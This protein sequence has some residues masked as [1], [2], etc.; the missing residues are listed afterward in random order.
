MNKKN[1]TIFYKTYLL[2]DKGRRWTRLVALAEPP[3]VVEAL[4]VACNFDGQELDAH[5]QN[6]VLLRGVRVHVRP[7]QRE[8]VVVVQLVELVDERAPE[9]LARGRLH[10]VLVNLA[11]VELGKVLAER[12]VDLIVERG[13]AELAGIGTA[14]E[15]RRTI[16]SESAWRDIR[17]EDNCTLTLK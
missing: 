5:D 12:G 3:P 2:G 11:H 13:Q 15:L 17:P 8:E 10:L 6:A 16:S 14:Q 1:K 9:L 4:P 7:D